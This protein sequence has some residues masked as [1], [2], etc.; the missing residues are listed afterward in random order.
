LRKSRAE[1]TPKVQ[2]RLRI[3]VAVVAGRG[4]IQFYNTDRSQRL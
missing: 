2:G 4:P 3:T 1:V